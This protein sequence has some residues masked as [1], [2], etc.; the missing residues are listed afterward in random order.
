VFLL[1]FIWDSI[2]YDNL[3]RY[4]EYGI[5]FACKILGVNDIGWDYA[6][7]TGKETEEE[8]K[9]ITAYDK[10]Y[11]AII[12]NPYI[13][14]ILW[15]KSKDDEYVLANIIAKM[16]HE[17]RHAWQYKN[18]IFDESKYSCFKAAGEDYINNEMEIDAFA[19]EE[20]VLKFILED[21]NAEIDFG[22]PQPKIHEK[23]FELYKKYNFNIG[24]K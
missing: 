4:I 7:I 11:N 9:I 18:G 13:L 21:D 10:E 5:V 23:A 15:D 17:V 3:D 22:K 20:A 12:V 16:S 1:S 2:N 8:L 24:V 14:R 6:Q 19:F